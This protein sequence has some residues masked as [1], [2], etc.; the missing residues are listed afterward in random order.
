MVIIM[1]GNSLMRVTPSCKGWT[2]GV[3]MWCVCGEGGLAEGRAIRV[4]SVQFSS[5]ITGI[6]V[7]ALDRILVEGFGSEKTRKPIDTETDMGR[8]R[9]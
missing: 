3:C 8:S 9:H 6:L 1:G 5:T 2:G 7:L 4:I